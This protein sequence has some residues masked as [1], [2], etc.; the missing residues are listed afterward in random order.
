LTDNTLR[1]ELKKR[2]R[3]RY[4]HWVKAALC[5]FVA[6]S[7]S[8]KA[9]EYVHDPDFAFGSIQ[10]MGSRKLSCEDILKMSGCRRPINIF[11]LSTTR[12]ENAIKHDVRF[13]RGVCRYKWPGVF[14]VE[15][16][17]RSPAIFVEDN[18]GA[19][20]K[21]DY[22]GVI[23]SISKGISDGSAPVLVNEILENVFEGDVVTSPVIL[24]VLQFM[25][26]ISYEACQA[27]AELNIDKF[28]NL[29]VVLK[30]GLHVVIGALDE[31][32]DR[33]KTFLTI[34]NEVR[35][36]NIDVEYI[37]MRFEKPFIRVRQKRG[38]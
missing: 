9:W 23:M 18:F 12:V 30:N 33:S 6:L 27:I 21:I 36:K 13:V 20:V 10:I 16:S 1:Y 26:G 4:I 14:Y 2:R 3:A 31:V 17:E 5:F 15:V 8:Y 7:V 28:R 22:E 32:K 37:D 35:E 19:Y 34:F 29:H 11:N 25:N 24:Q 38:K